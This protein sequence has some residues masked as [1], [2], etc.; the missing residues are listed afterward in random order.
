MKPWLSKSVSWLQIQEENQGVKIKN[1]VIN[2]LFF[3]FYSFWHKYSHSY[4]AHP[5]LHKHNSV[6]GSP[7]FLHL[8]R[9]PHFCLHPHLTS[10]MHAFEASSRVAQVG[11]RMSPS[12]VHPNFNA[13]NAGISF[14]SA[15]DQMLK[16]IFLKVH[17]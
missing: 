17:L 12:F 4:S 5:P 1:Y 6:Q 15:C 11:F 10:A 16:T 9:L 3:L 13:S 14:S 8:H 2:F 7:W